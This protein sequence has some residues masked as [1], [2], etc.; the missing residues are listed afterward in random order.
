MSYD[1]VEIEDME[2]N[3]ELK[4]FTYPCPCGDLFQITKDEL[5]MVTRRREA[6]IVSRWDRG[7]VLWWLIRFPCGLCRVRA[8]WS[9][10]PS[11]LGVRVIL[12]CP[13]RLRVSVPTSTSSATVLRLWL[14]RGIATVR[15]GLLLDQSRGRSCG[16]DKN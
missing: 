12:K 2:W 16:S 14:L 9:V 6:C 8:R 7:R 5:K 3:E 1:N 10:P 4:S 13:I 11:P 15:S